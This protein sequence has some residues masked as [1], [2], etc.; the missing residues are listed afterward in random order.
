M[1]IERW[2]QV[3]TWLTEGQTL[4]PS[5]SVDNPVCNHPDGQ[6]NLHDWP[7]LV[8]PGKKLRISY[9]TLEGYKDTGIVAMFLFTGTTPLGTSHAIDDPRCTPTLAAEGGSRQFHGLG[10]EF[11][12]GTTVNLRLQNAQPGHYDW[13]YGW[14]VGGELRDI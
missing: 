11:G 3:D 9:M 1:V 5:S 8:P 2:V 12:P 4:L 13:I 14:S 6:L 7:Y 10:W